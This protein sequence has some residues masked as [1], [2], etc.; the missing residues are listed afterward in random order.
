MTQRMKTEY[1]QKQLD[2]LNTNFKNKKLELSGRYGYSALD[3]SNG[4]TL[5]TCKTK[6][7]IYDICYCINSV[8]Y[9]IKKEN[10]Q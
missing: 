3:W 4:N 9:E 2:R 5:T 6:S 1:I 10:K 8:L 7:E